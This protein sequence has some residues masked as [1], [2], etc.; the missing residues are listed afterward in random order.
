MLYKISVIVPI[1]KVLP[2][3]KECV[4]SIL[5][6]TYHNIEVI[7]VDDGSP[8]ECGMV[9]DEFQ[10]MD[11]RVVVIH[12]KNSGLS[13][14]RNAGI[15]IA[16]GD[17]ILFVD[18]DDWII[19][20]AIEWLVECQRNTNA[21]VI[22]GCFFREEIDLKEEDRAVKIFKG[23]DFLLS[24]FFKTE[25]WLNLYNKNCFVNAKF[26]VGIL[27]EDVALVYKIMYEAERVAYTNIKFYFYR[28]R[29]NSIITECF[30]EKRLV[31]ID[32][33]EDQIA[34]YK[35]RNE[36]ELLNKAY[37]SYYSVLL[38]CAWKVKKISDGKKIRKQ[39]ICKYRENIINFVKIDF[40]QFKTKL[41]LIISFLFPDVW[42]YTEMISEKIRMV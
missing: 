21:D 34:F 23:R 19:P 20:S 7:L 27:H 40:L 4:N 36:M 26:P 13:A 32:I 30:N 12:Q 41:L 31:I 18:G 42:K 11:N 1:Y 33:I 28:K 2:Y 14:A 6:Q 10:K 39:I 22:Q 3:I 15:D 35:E 38:D 17:F 29:S 16:S 24:D 25:A 9:C 8:D 37:Y 5:G